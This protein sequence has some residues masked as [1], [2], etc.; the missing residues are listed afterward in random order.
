MEK[1]FGRGVQ[2]KMGLES[3]ERKKWKQGGQVVNAEDDG[4]LTRDQL[5]L[6][7]TLADEWR[8]RSTMVWGG[9][10][11]DWHPKPTFQEA[12][13]CHQTSGTRGAEQ[14][15]R[16]SA[17]GGCS[18]E[19]ERHGSWMA[20]DTPSIPSWTEPKPDLPHSNPLHSLQTPTSPETT[21]GASQSASDQS[22]ASEAFIPWQ[23]GRVS[24]TDE[25]CV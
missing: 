22:V 6:S 21:L 23:S 16:G 25:E 18:I 5:G 1:Q 19:A 11:V 24:T 8:M 20:H 2:T 15:A 7:K 17:W 10:P 12:K 14:L 3:I 4:C 13:V 9:V